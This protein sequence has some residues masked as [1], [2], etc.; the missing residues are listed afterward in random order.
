MPNDFGLSDAALAAFNQGLTAARAAVPGAANP[1]TTG[2]GIPGITG[3]AAL[4]NPTAV[5]TMG[6]SFQAGQNP[7]SGALLGSTHEPSPTAAPSPGVIPKPAAP[8]APATHALSPDTTMTPTFAD[9]AAGGAVDNAMRNFIFKVRGND[10]STLYTNVASHVPADAASVTT[11]NPAVNGGNV[12]VV[13]ALAAAQGAAGMT[14]ADVTLA[15]QQM[16]SDRVTAATPAPSYNPVKERLQGLLLNLIGQAQ[17]PG[18][19]T[20]QN[21]DGSTTAVYRPNPAQILAAASSLQNAD[22]NASRA[23]VD[24]VLRQAEL[25]QTAAYQQGMLG[26]N[27]RRLEL[28]GQTAAAQQAYRDRA[29]AQQRDLAEDTL[30]L[31]QLI[32]GN[33]LQVQQANTKAR[34]LEAAARVYSGLSSN[35]L[36]TGTPEQNAVAAQNVA[37]MLTASPEELAKIAAANA[38]IYGGKP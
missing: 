1:S 30:G 37:K 24:A 32:A 11:L 33:Q 3:A 5:S 27:N 17:S 34:Q 29:L 18:P 31:R 26:V 36:N 12:S 25:G 6:S 35:P 9:A 21:T 19:G 20:I 22:T 2:S 10:G 13:P 23:G 38:A 8:V 7:L 28:E 16:A 4:R 15:N 14:P